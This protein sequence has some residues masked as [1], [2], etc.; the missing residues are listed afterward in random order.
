MAFRSGI[1]QVNGTN[2]SPIKTYSQAYA[3]VVSGSRNNFSFILPAG[4]FKCSLSYQVGFVGTGQ[5]TMNNLNTGLSGDVASSTP[6]PPMPL[7]STNSI[8]LFGVGAVTGQSFSGGTGFTN[9][10]DTYISLDTETTIYLFNFVS[11]DVTSGTPTVSISQSV[12]I[13]EIVG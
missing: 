2:A 7:S 4:T 5:V 1:N 3:S 10:Q 11:F 12:T 6:I 8:I 9:F 13:T